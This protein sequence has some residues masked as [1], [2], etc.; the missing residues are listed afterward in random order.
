MRHR[1]LA[2]AQLVFASLAVLL[3][4]LSGWWSWRVG[5]RHGL[6]V[7]LSIVLITGVS[8]ILM[9]L[10]TRAPRDHSA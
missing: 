5:D 2:H 4:G 10:A 9:R 6:M 1:T 7:A 3:A 8:S